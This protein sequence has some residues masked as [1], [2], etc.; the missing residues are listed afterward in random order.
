MLDT[1]FAESSTSSSWDFDEVIKPPRWILPVGIASVSIGAIWSFLCLLDV[2]AAIE[3]DF[4][5]PKFLEGFLGYFL[6]L[7]V[8]SFL[9]VELRRFKMR[10]A[11]ESPGT[12][13]S[14]AGL[15]MANK[16]KYLAITGLLFSLI[17]IYVAVLPFA[18]KWA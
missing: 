11:K 17:A 9:F 13:D 1:D 8:P 2:I 6:T 15:Q 14:Y 12:Y 18:E 5:E 4:I 10:K 7:M 16:L 3:I